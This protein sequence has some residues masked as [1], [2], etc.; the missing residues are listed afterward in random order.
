MVLITWVRQAFLISNQKLCEKTNFQGTAYK[1][2]LINQLSTQGEYF[3]PKFTKYF[4]CFVAL[5][6][7]S[8]AMVIAGWS[9]HLN[10][11]FPGQ[12]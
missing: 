10:T 8:T 5:R 9:F 3:K 11:L 4:V 7:K 2:I 12:A 6:P 1:N